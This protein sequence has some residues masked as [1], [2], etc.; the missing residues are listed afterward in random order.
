M[1]IRIFLLRYVGSIMETFILY[2]QFTKPPEV[3]PSKQETVDFWMEL[4]LQACKPTVSTDRC[5]VRPHHSSQYIQ[6]YL[7]RA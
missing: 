7:V 3:K 4:M 6:L 5:P 2:H 1:L